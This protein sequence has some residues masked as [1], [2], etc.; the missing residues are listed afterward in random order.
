MA[1]GGELQKV[2]ELCGPDEEGYILT[3]FLADKLAEQLDNQDLDTIK[4]VLDPKRRGKI[5]FDQFK[6]AIAEIQESSDQVT[7]L[8]EPSADYRINGSGLTEDIE[9]CSLNKL[10]DND[11]KI[12]HGS[13]GPESSF[14]PKTSTPYYK[15]DEASISDPENTYNEYDVPDCD[16]MAHSVNGDDFMESFEAVGE[17]PNGFKSR[18]NPE[19]LSLPQE[20][21]FRRHGSMRRS[22]RRAH[23]LTMRGASPGLVSDDP[24]LLDETSSVTSDLEDLS[25]K[26]DIL[27]DHVA[28]LTEEKKLQAQYEAVNNEKQQLILRNHELEERLVNS[29]EKVNYLRKDSELKLEDLRT[30]LTREHQLVLEVLQGKL[31]SSE[32][33]YNRLTCEFGEVKALLNQMKEENILLQTKVEGLTSQVMQTNEEYRRLNNQFNANRERAEEDKADLQDMNEKLRIDLEE[34]MADKN[35]LVERLNSMDL[36]QSPSAAMLSAKLSNLEMENE[37]LKNANDDL[38]VQLARNI[39]DARTL[40]GSAPVDSIADEMA[41]ATRDE[42]VEALQKTEHENAQLRQYLDK[43][44]LSVLEKDP[45]ILEIK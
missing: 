29:E 34:T 23:S 20:S 2:F 24:S 33:E 1:D 16:D 22:H 18:R 45:S 19:H 27:Q 4:G 11:E 13:P 3:D 8:P 12:R 44:I 25:E 39:V 42:V 40:M 9:H 32:N 38:N 5:S 17:S 28:K 36:S 31:N 14:Q 41:S 6:T 7:S 35:A 26:V 15:D 37:R 43:I 10:I 30:K 21:N